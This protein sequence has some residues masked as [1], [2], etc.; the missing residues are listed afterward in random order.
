MKRV[1]NILVT[2]LC[3][4][5]LFSCTHEYS[6]KTNSYVAFG[7]TSFSV[8]EDVG[9]VYIPVSAYNSESASG[10]VFF[11]VID[12]T[13]V[14]GT[15]FTVEPANGVLDFNGNST[16]NI[17]IS[18]IE[19]P[20]VLTGSLKFT[21]ELSAVAGGIT[22]LGGVYSASV[23]IKD[24][25]VV[26]DWDYVTGK[27]TAQDYDNGAPDGGTY[28]VTFSKKGEDTVVLNN[29]W[30]GKMNIEGA[31]TFNTEEN[32]ASISFP[33]GQ[34]VFDATE[35]DMGIMTLIGYD[36]VRG[37]WYLNTPAVATVTS[38]GIVLG[39]WNLVYN[40]NRLYGQSYT[41]V[42]IK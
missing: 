24:N 34:P 38:G 40:T 12:G 20:G 35:Y 29:L 11:K 19:H 21:I 27:W 37:G 25:D 15:D 30:G 41:T 33:F 32:T 17:V 18:V 28:E 23:E 2:T 14:Q 36:T 13:A 4:A 9:T 1:I 31:I 26:V 22:D 42:F 10:S 7:E 6:F 16:E 3:A 5:V 8:K 39:P